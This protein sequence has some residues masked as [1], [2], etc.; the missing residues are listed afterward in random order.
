[1]LLVATQHSGWRPRSC[2][3]H[4]WLLGCLITKDNTQQQK[5]V[6]QRR[7]GSED[8]YSEAATMKAER[9]DNVQVLRELLAESQRAQAVAKAAQAQCEKDLADA[10]RERERIQKA[11]LTRDG[12][13]RTHNKVATEASEAQIEQVLQGSKA[14]RVVRDRET[15]GACELHVDVDVDRQREIQNARQAVFEETLQTCRKE[16][17]RAMRKVPLPL[18]HPKESQF[19]VFI[20]IASVCNCHFSNSVCVRAR[21]LASLSPSL[22][23]SVSL[24]LCARAQVTEEETKVYDAMMQANAP[25]LCAVSKV[26]YVLEACLVCIHAHSKTHKTDRHASAHRHRHTQ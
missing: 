16:F 25:S 3:A 21:V 9:E 23:P 22:S 7:K 5:T 2:A 4:D 11:M 8:G 26:Q 10:V 19:S 14:D 15:T 17:M 12:G 1:M 18:F 24:C 20:H 13:G 6:V